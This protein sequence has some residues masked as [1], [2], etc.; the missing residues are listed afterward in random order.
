MTVTA[1]TLDASEVQAP[2]ICIDSAKWG[3]AFMKWRMAKVREELEWDAY[4]ATPKDHPDRAVLSDLCEDSMSAEA[5]SWRE[6]IE[7]PAPDLQ[8]LRWKLDQFVIVEQDEDHS[9]A[10]A[11]PIALHVKA[12]IQRLLPA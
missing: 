12:D 6:L 5:A 9:V 2:A 7:T 10:W 11:A 1:D 3:A 8:A 4:R